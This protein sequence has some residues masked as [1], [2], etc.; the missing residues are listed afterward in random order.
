MIVGLLGSAVCARSRSPIAGGDV[1]LHSDD[2][3]E[4]RFAGLLLKLPGGVQI[5]VIGNRQGGLLE[6][7]GPPDQVFDPVCAVEEGVFGM[8]VEVYEGH[9]EEDSD[10]RHM[11][12]R[13][14]AAAFVV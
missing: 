7:L 1:C 11:R 8:A 12:Q 9:R 4:L 13:K 5:T 6:L 14:P 10:P 3:L 2:R